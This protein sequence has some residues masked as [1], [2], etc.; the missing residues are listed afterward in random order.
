MHTPLFLNTPFTDVSSSCL[1]THTFEP[2]FAFLHTSAYPTRMLPWAPAAQLHTASLRADYSVYKTACLVAGYSRALTRAGT[3]LSS[4]RPVRRR[5]RYLLRNARRR[6][7]IAEHADATLHFVPIP[8]ASDSSIY[9]LLLGGHLPRVTITSTLTCLSFH[10]A[11]CCRYLKS[12]LFAVIV[13]LP[14]YRYRYFARPISC[15][16]SAR[17]N[18]A[19]LRRNWAARHA[20]PF[21]F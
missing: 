4:P 13:T 15:C 12:C 11:R 18:Y 7:L 2:Q 16:L 5:L 1:T 6:R 21:H 19:V 3:S 14:A 20:V 17:P 10:T 9:L 8:H